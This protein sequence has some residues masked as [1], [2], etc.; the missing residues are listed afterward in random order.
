MKGPT[1]TDP[2][3]DELRKSADYGLNGLGSPGAMPTALR[4]HGSGLILAV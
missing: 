1:V 4:G 2:N 3:W